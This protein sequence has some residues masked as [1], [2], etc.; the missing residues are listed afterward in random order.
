MQEPPAPTQSRVTFHDVGVSA[1]PLMTV[2]DGERLKLK[3][4]ASTHGSAIEPWPAHE[5]VCEIARAKHQAESLIEQLKDALKG[6]GVDLS[7]IR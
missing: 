6:M 3:T 7:T 1:T 2:W 4:T 5:E